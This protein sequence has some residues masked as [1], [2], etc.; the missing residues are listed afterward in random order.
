LDKQYA[1]FVELLK[2][3]NV[4]ISFTDVVTQMPTYA[5]FLKDILSNRRKLDD[6]TVTLTEKVSAIVMNKL[7]PKLQDPGSFTIPCSIGSTKF[8]RALCDL[9]ASVSLMPKSIFDRIGVGELV[10]TKIS[11][12]LADR[13]VKYLVG[14]VEYLPLQVRKFY[15]PIDFVI[16][17]MDED[18]NT[19]LII[20][21]PFLNTAGTQID[22]RGRKLTF[23]IGK[24]KVKFDMFKALK[25]PTNDGNFY[26]VDMIDVIVKEEFEKLSVDDSIDR[27][28]TYP[29]D[30]EFE[31]FLEQM[32]LEISKSE[33]RR[34]KTAQPAE[35]FQNCGPKEDFA[36]HKNC[37]DGGR[38]FQSQNC[39]PKSKKCGPQFCPSITFSTPEGSDSTQNPPSSPKVELKPLPSTLRVEVF[40]PLT[41]EKYN[42][43]MKEKSRKAVI[44]HDDSVS[45][46][47][48][49]DKS[50]QTS[51]KRLQ[52]KCETDWLSALKVEKKWVCCGRK[53]P[54][55]EGLSYF[56]SKPQPLPSD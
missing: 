47:R 29:S 54:S 21:R 46:S 17:E 38:K 23:E 19:P 16:I 34:H 26:R 22:V 51:H 42:E 53:R 18:P 2:K 36:D 10:P 6:E 45:T 12:Q 43:I 1:R 28:I 50:F 15:I 44:K 30:G 9:R 31:R 49:K 8:D 4:N 41:K 25:Y 35:N 11:L 37:T 14:Q 7:P 56:F 24:E 3:L 27:L 55:E 13:S 52:M 40:N 39:G 20:G 33:E 48:A 32:E 5:K